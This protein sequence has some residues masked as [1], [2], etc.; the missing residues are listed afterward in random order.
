LPYLNSTENDWVIE[1]KLD[2]N[3]AGIASSTVE[4]FV[5]SFFI[6]CN[7]V[8]HCVNVCKRHILVLKEYLAKSENWSWIRTE[9]SGSIYSFIPYLPFPARKVSD[10]GYY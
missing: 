9:K 6:L 3:I 2:I 5:D 7:Y 4:N 1:K 8:Q 10:L